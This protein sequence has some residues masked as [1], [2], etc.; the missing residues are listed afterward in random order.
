MSI[1]FSFNQDGG[2]FVLA[3]GRVLGAGYV[4]GR[5]GSV[6]SLMG[7]LQDRQ[8]GLHQIVA[9]GINLVGLTSFV[10]IV[11][12]AARL[13]TPRVVD[14]LKDGSEVHFFSMGT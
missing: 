13:R 1:E 9:I 6:V 10:Q 5:R 8:P 4:E 7:L 11:N 12:H 3:M 14:S 2:G